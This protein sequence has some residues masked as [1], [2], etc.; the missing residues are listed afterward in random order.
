MKSK[1]AYDAIRNA[2]EADTSKRMIESHYDEQNFGNFVIA[3]EENGE[4]KT[5]VN[6][7]GFVTASAGLDCIATVP[8]LHDADEQTL[9]RQ[10]AI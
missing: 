3:F 10:L 9:L 5:V 4:R 7:R 6:E 8:S 2:V 1:A